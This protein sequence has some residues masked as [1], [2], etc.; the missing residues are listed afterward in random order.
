MNI[1]R[2]GF[3]SL[4]LRS[5]MLMNNYSLMMHAEDMFGNETDHNHLRD[6]LL[7]VDMLPLMIDRHMRMKKIAAY[8]RLIV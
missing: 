2:V 5:N 4:H 7:F 3:D 1:V 6:L 8:S